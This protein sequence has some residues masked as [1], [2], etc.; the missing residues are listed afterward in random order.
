MELIIIINFYNWGVVIFLFKWLRWWGEILILIL[1][2][3]DK[4]SVILDYIVDIL[5]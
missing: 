4:S 3:I 1:E 5:L 2:W